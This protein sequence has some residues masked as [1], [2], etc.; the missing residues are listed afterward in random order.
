MHWEIIGDEAAVKRVAGRLTEE[1]DMPLT[2]DDVRFNWTGVKVIHNEND[3]TP[4]PGPDWTP[5]EAMAKAD[6]KLDDLKTQLT[7]QATTITKLAGH[8]TAL[9]A[10]LEKLAK[11][12]G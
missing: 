11:G 7:A 5:A 10:Q 3:P 9:A 6:T 8:V 12:T 2:K 4:T 1:R